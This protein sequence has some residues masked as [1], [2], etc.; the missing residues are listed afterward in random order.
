MDILSPTYSELKRKVVLQEELLKEMNEISKKYGAL[1][2]QLE[3]TE[4]EKEVANLKIEQLEN[5]KDKM[6]EN[7]ER[8]IEKY[9]EELEDYEL[10]INE[11]KDKMHQIKSID[12]KTAETLNCKTKKGACVIM[13]YRTYNK[14]KEHKC[15]LSWS[16]SCYRSLCEGIWKRNCWCSS[17]IIRS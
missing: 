9:E 15:E 17:L 1:Q 8:E 7:Y 4:I 12:K 13:V 3:Q 2:F 14:M 6:F 11:L 10:M 5:I 16:Y